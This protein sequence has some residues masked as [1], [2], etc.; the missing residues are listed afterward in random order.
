MSKNAPMIYNFEV[1]KERVIDTLK[2]T[3]LNK[4]LKHIKGN[5]ICVG[6]GGSNVK[7]CIQNLLKHWDGD[8]ECYIRGDEIH[9]N[10]VRNPE[11]YYSCMLKEDVNV[12]LDSITVTDVNPDTPN[13]L[14]VEWTGGKIEFRDE[15]AIVRFGEKPKTVQAVRKVVKTVE[16]PVKTETSTDTESD[17]PDT[18]MS[19]LQ[20]PE[21]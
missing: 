10:K 2:L 6:S 12:I 1:L 14:I 21:L 20:A 15:K 8:V 18:L 5:T 9:I 3:D 17:H 16:K 4:E 13:H 11:K 19:D 7:D